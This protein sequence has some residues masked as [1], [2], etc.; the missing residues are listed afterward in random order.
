MTYSTFTAILTY[1]NILLLDINFS[2]KF[3]AVKIEK[4][5]IMSF[6]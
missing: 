4:D 6:T 5:F 1:I 3:N 2:S